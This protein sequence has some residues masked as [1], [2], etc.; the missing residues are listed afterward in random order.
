MPVTVALPFVLRRSDDVITDAGITSTSESVHGLVR[1]DGE[2][3][4]VQ[5]RAARAV[6]RVGREIRTDRDVDPVREAAVPLAGVAGAAVRW[7]WRAWPP[8]PVL[9]LTAADLRA[10]EALVGAAGLRSEHPAQLVL[11]LRRADLGAARAFAAELEMAVADRMLR[12][13]EASGR[14]PGPGARETL[15]RPGGGAPP[16]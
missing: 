2:Q 9:V 3:L 14:L 8:G 4:V 12:D 1:L 13:A 16:R 6:E 7:R 5:W 10:F 11:P 15:P